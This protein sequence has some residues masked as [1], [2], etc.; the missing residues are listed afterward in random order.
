MNGPYCPYYNNTPLLYIYMYV[1]CS[2]VPSISAFLLF[3]F[4]RVYTIEKLE[5]PEGAAS[6]MYM[7]RSVLFYLTSVCIL[8][9]ILSVL[10]FPL[11]G[12]Y[13][14]LVATSSLI[15][16]NPSPTQGSGSSFVFRAA[17]FHCFFT[18]RPPNFLLPKVYEATCFRGAWPGDLYVGDSWSGMSPSE[19]ALLG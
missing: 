18:E 17:N 3:F 19:W 9:V 6:Y 12:L 14:C 4:L 1:V 2:L 13:M 8:I 15:L 5:G 11:R 10:H 7:Y 16:S